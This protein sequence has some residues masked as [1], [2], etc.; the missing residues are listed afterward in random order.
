LLL[1]R[2]WKYDKNVMLDGGKN[3][4]T[5]WKDG[6]KVVLFPIKDEGKTENM[7]SKRDFVKEAK[8]MR[9]CYALVVQKGVV[10]DRQIP[11]EVA[12]LL[13]ELLI[14]SLMN[15]LMVFQ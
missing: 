4:Y 3:T 7:L 15:Y 6:S 9:L 5:F 2:P 14:L 1:G 12:K 8:E 10:E 13:E 11:T